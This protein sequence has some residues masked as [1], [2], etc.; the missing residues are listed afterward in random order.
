MSE[1]LRTTVIAFA[2]IAAAFTWYAIRTARIPPSSPDRLVSELRLAQF[3][4]LLL[5]L[6]AGAYVGFA[7]VAERTQGVGLDIAFTIGFLLI[8][9]S[10]LVYDPRQALTVLALAFAAHAVI[11]VA[12]RPGGLPE[13]IAPRWYLVGCAIFDVYVGALCYYPILRR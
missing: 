9:A 10:T 5:A 11:D 6:I 2:G 12:H 4:A 8:A 1:G 7:V 13:A 3:A